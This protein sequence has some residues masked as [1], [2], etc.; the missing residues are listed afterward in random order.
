[1]RIFTVAAVL[2]ATLASVLWVTLSCRASEPPSAPILRV[3]TEMH[4]ALI[5]RLIVDPVRERLITAGD[6]KTLRIW[7]LPR[8]RL[9]HVLRGPIG[10]GHEGRIYA[11]A[12]SP[13]GNT[14]A[15]GGWTG[16]DWDRQ[17]SVYLF[18]A[19]S[20]D[21]VRRIPGFPDVIGSLAWSKDGQRL[22]VGLHADGGL[23]VLRTSDYTPVERDADYRDKILGADF[24]RDGRLAVTALDGFVRLYDQN[25]RLLG[26][27]PT[28]PGR[29]PL[30][31]RF[32]PDGQLLALSFNDAVA[33]AVLR[34]ADLSLAFTP[35]TSQ[36]PGLLAVTEVAWADDGT[37]LYACGELA[38][39]QRGALFRWR[40]GGRGT[41]EMLQ[42]NTH[43]RIADLQ[44]MPRGGVAFAAEDP[45]VGVLDA[46]GRQV[47][48][49][50]P[51]IAQFGNDESV[52][53]VSSDGARVQFAL[54]ER[55]DRPVR[56]SLLARELRHGTG[57]EL[58]AAVTAS[59]G[60]AIADWLDGSKPVINGS[61]VQLDDY[62]VGR[63][64]AVSPD[65]L[66]L[67]LGTEWA[68]RA[69]DRSANLRWKT[70]V[71]GVVR[72]VVVTLRG[73]VAVAALADGTIRW[74]RMEDG[75]EFL[76]LF[77]DGAGA[78]WIA[79]TPAGYYASS[80]AGD[81]YVGWHLN[82][83]KDDAA[84]FHRAIQFERLL[85]RPDL[86]EEAFRGRGRPPGPSRRA[87]PKFDISQLASIAPPRVRLEADNVRRG[88]DG[89]L[90][91][92]LRVSARATALPMLDYTVFVND[93]PVTLARDRELPSE[94]RAAFVTDTQIAL[95]PGE[96]RVRVEISTASSLAF[97]ETQIDVAGPPGA[98]LPPG[99]L[100]VLAVGVN[101][102][103]QLRN[104]AL[105]LAARERTRS[106][107]LGRGRVQPLPEGPRPRAVRSRRG[108]AR[109]IAHRRGARVPRRRR[110]RRHRRTLPCLP[111]R[112]RRRGKLRSPARDR[113]HRCR[114]RSRCPRRRPPSSIPWDTPGYAPAARRAGGS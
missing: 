22:A 56:F 14:I 89:Q 46:D 40:A 39:Q 52:L 59:R 66:T 86:V 12:V 80:P 112:E 70:A 106:R 4:G 73:D 24:D 21:L 72:G 98:A 27:V 100:Y 74:Y 36:V 68:L 69:Y 51:Q 2:R 95:Q 84:D 47:F 8:G 37:T 90:R 79:W 62:E 103:P 19:R 85:Y 109:P 6:D 76:A 54:G 88:D 25:L 44:P 33:P 64:Y 10:P 81:N 104:A 17:G 94:R 41:L 111:W 61:P 5:R 58:T 42:T 16:W 67:I 31:V 82:R 57:S 3:E 38:G 55:G 11:L 78:E 1:M 108:E 13:D 83:G 26:R 114:W 92:T 107:T 34:A 30:T 63:T 53:R 77:V 71:P 9:E 32:S 50:G 7:Q 18:D 23:W 45:A 28:A 29:K 60:F 43:L 113:A 75:V 49:R 65:D 99:D 97:A 96:N 93:I 87:Q 110:G 102:F 105:K 101:E 91:G 35:D 20:G 15:A 48:A